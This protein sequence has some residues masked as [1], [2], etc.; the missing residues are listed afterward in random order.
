VNLLLSQKD[1]IGTGGG[2]R[3][4]DEVLCNGAV[5]NQCVG[6]VTKMHQVIYALVEASTEDTAL[7]CGR[8]AFDRLAGAGP[9]NAAIF[10]YSVMFD[11]ER[12][13]VAG[14]AQ[15]GE[16]P[17]VA[18]V[19]SDDGEK[20]L[21]RGWEKKSCYGCSIYSPPTIIMLQTEISRRPVQRR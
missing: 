15:W 6:E 13:S 5:S 12:S 18:P 17:V 19:D 4:T 20:L 21:E 9:D 1:F 3:R 2:C 14:K 7:A 16:L 8:S 11:D 10:D